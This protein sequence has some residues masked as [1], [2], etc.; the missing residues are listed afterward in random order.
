MHDY[1]VE[2]NKAANALSPCEESQR[3]RLERS[4]SMYQRCIEDI[5][6]ALALMNKNPDIEELHDL[7]RRL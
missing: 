5:D 1:P 4:R 7:L 3:K 6:R 2:V